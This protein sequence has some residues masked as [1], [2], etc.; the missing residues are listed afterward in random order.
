MDPEAAA[1]RLQAEEGKERLRQI[2]ES[3]PDDKVSR[4]MEYGAVISFETAE[5]KKEGWLRRSD[6]P[7]RNEHCLVKIVGT[8][9]KMF[10]LTLCQ[11]DQE[12]AEDTFCKH[13]GALPATHDRSF[14][15]SPAT[16]EEEQP[17]DLDDA[18][19]SE[20]LLRSDESGY[21]DDADWNDW[22]GPFRRVAFCC[23]LLVCPQSVPLIGGRAI[24]YRPVSW[25]GRFRNFSRVRNF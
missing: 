14:D 2:Q 13:A 20:S 25:P 11:V 8:L 3:I 12:T 1:D 18:H 5:G 6:A 15:S 21:W 19:K 16:T 24:F 10:K 7:S 4:L 22:Y 9:E 23:V 17:C